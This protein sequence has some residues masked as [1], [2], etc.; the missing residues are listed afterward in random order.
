MINL[1]ELISGFK[2][3]G[4]E[5]GDV[6]LVHSSYRSFGGVEG[7]PQTVIDALLDVIGTEGTLIV[8]TF[9]F[10]FCDD[11]NEKG[12]GFFDVQNTASEMGYLTEL[13]RKM[14]GAK[15]TADPIY[16]V[17]IYGKLCD[18]F[19]SV[20]ERIVFGEGSIFG[21]LTKYDAKQMLIGLSY[22]NSWTYVH[23]VEE[24]EGVDYRYHKE[25]SGTIIDGDKKYKATYIFNVRD[26]SKGIET[27]VNPV[28]EVLEK[29]GVV[30]IRK[31]GDSTVKL[32][33]S[34]KKVYEITMELL[35]EDKTLF[36]EIE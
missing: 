32:L 34:T 21:L 29:K 33:T 27:A 14:P 3:L 36:Y 6:L 13:V 4:L 9:T 19:A 24:M 25:F 18:E 8:P 30:N 2:E 23:H 11:F 17:A 35:K 31:I 20:S 22:N 28:G 10:K 7:G 26:I 5:N 1:T 16:S 15:R 12:E